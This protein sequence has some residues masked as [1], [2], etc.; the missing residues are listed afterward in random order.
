MFMRLLYLRRNIAEIDVLRSFYD[1]IVIPELQKLEGCLFAGLLQSGEDE[2]EGISLTL[3]D[4][5]THAENYETSGLFK[6][7][8]KQ[9]SP[10]LDKSSEWKVQLSEDLELEFAQKDDEPELGEYEV[11]MHERVKSTLF[12][13]H[14]KMYVRI[15]SHIL[16]K[17][18]LSEFREIYSER[19][20]PQL[21][22]TK[23]CQFSYLIESLHKGNE[24]VSISIWDSKKDADEFERSGLFN[25][26]VNELRPTFS[27]FFQWKMALE[28]RSGDK[29]QTNEDVK[30]SDYKVVTGKNLRRNAP[31]N[32]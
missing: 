20:I 5:K 3:W 14:S 10:F 6:K 12:E 25:E 30:I 1:A 22:S 7:L 15:V 8:L 16:Q 24:V 26:L 4:T 19:I 27:Q 2:K 28:S 9:A 18:K 32:R 29:V 21:R 31:E 23:G 11:T 13:K 17:D